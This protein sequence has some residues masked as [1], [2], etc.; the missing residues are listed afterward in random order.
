MQKREESVSAE[1]KKFFTCMALKKRLLSRMV[2]F[3]LKLLV[4]RNFVASMAVRLF[5]LL[6]DVNSRVK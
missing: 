2:L 5:L 1:F 6:E 3:Y 4:W